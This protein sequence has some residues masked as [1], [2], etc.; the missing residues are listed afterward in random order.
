MKFLVSPSILMLS[1]TSSRS[2]VRKPITSSTAQ[3][4]DRS[5]KI[6][7]QWEDEEEVVGGDAWMTEQSGAGA[8]RVEFVYLSFC[9]FV[10]LFAALSN[11]LFVSF[12]YLCVGLLF[13]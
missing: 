5:F 4:G 9:P 10:C 13:Y 11:F 6:G 3:G 8:A 1:T 12:A 2:D 7:S